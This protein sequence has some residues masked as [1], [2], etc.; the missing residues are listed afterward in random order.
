MAD[1]Q[2]TPALPRLFTPC[3]LRDITFKNRI[4][5]SPMCQYSCEDG[6]AND[7]HLVH[8]GCRA[9]GGAALVIMEAT[10]VT[11]DGRI[12]PGDMGIWRDAH[13]DALRPVAEFISKNGSVPGIQ[14]AH[15][16]RK[17]S[18][19]APWL[20]G[21]VIPPDEK[22]GWTPVAPSAVPFRAG[23]PTPHELSIAEIAELVEH[24]RIAAQRALAAGFQVVE[25]HGAHGYLI[26]EF[27]SPLSNRRNDQYGGSF[28]NRI[29]FALETAQAVRETWPAEWPVFMRLSCT[30]WADG[31]WDLDQSV[32]LSIRLRDIGIDLIDC[33]SG[34]LVPHVRIPVGPGYQV[35]FA[36]RI[37]KEAGIATGAVGMITDARQA[38]SII[39]NEQA[40]MV[41][42][43]RA[44]LRD[45][46]W[47]LHA[48]R[49]LGLEP[50]APVQY[51][52][53]F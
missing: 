13:I 24:F 22:G 21:G 18:T 40:D 41:L 27:L 35:P 15:A 2:D 10:A 42:L 37:G 53:A 6:F 5:V 26:H 39:A 50:P 47:P 11:A 17:A 7:W 38:E 16:G 28:D 30:D 1:K 49:E 12:S 8:L 51:A 52:R 14:L 29:R 3:R 45:P 9:V 34:A 23:D 19:T 25:I 48:A 33:S 4:A 46:Y 44:M 20:G 31:G 43:A 36:E 32:Q